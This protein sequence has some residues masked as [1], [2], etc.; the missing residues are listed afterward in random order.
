MAR[1]AIVRQES[2]SIQHS[3]ADPL[4]SRGFSERL[5]E[6]G[7][8]EDTMSTKRERNSVEP[9]FGGVTEVAPDG[10]QRV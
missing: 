3:E 7:R 2:D 5:E 10:A 1:L 4:S 9:I 8:E 6:D